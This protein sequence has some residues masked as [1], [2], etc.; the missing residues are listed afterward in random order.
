MEFAPEALDLLYNVSHGNPRVINLIV[1]KSLNRGHLDRTWVIT[2]AIVTVA[3]GELG[4]AKPALTAD[5]K[6]LPLTPAMPTTVRAA[7]AR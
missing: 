4:Y 6:S 3:L 7:Q 5:A 2:P 1:D